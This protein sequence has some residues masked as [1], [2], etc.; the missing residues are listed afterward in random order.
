MEGEEQKLYIMVNQLY[1]LIIL[2]FYI[3]A[4][5]PVVFCVYE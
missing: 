5:F 4:I 2:Q 1:K 3:F